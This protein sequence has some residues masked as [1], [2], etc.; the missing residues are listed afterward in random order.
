MADCKK[1][2]YFITTVSR[3]RILKY[4]GQITQ[5]HVIDTEV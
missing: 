2:I 1:K 4:L 3:Q 5:K